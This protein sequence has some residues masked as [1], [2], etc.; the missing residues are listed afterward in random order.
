M[1]EELLS[2]QETHLIMT[3]ER[4]TSSSE[5]EELKVN[6]KEIRREF[7]TLSENLNAITVSIQLP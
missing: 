1:L 3:Q 2:I 4:D 7:S 5:H 6:F